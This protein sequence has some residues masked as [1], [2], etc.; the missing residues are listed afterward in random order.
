MHANELC[1]LMLTHWYA[2]S[3]FCLGRLMFSSIMEAAHR[4]LLFLPF[5]LKNEVTNTA[6]QLLLSL[7]LCYALLWQSS[8]PICGAFES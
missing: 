2:V 6:E 1:Q 8:R 5:R 3:S 4:P 7:L